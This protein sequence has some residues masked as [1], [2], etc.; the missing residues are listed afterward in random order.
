MWKQ[1]AT[2]R[3]LVLTGSSLWQPMLL[4][5]LHPSI[6]T[7]FVST[8]NPYHLFDVPYISTFINAYTGTPEN[9]AAV[10][11]KVTGQEEFTGINPIDP[12]CG[13]FVATL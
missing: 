6:P 5:L 7:V 11:R 1:P 2:K 4:G 10:L 8:A 13:D 3:L 9:V 12:F